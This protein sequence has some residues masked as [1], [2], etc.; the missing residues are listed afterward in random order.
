M[1]FFLKSLVDD[2][3]FLQGVKNSRIIARHVGIKILFVIRQGV[4][5]QLIQISLGAGENNGD[6]FFQRLVLGLF[7]DFHQTGATGQ[8]GLG[9][10]VK[11]GTETGKGGKLTILGQVE[12][13]GTGNLFHGLYLRG[14]TNPGYGETDVD[15]RP[16]AGEEQ[17]R[18]Q[19]HL[20]V[21]NGNYVGRNKGGY[22]TGLG[23]DDG[24]RGQRAGTEGIVYFRST[25]QQT[26]MVKENVTRIGLTS[27]RAAKQ[28]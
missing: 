13:K 10:G 7:Q 12:A 6:L 19:I 16:D 5:R 25:F 17:V 24:Q 28:Q 21:G 23:L 22:V 9:R 11:I 14:A 8:L 15:R 4:E 3:L 1:H 26:G 20:T 27:R 18:L 2:L